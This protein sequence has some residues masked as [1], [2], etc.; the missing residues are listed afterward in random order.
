MGMWRTGSHLAGSVC[1]ALGKAK[2]HKLATCRGPECSAEISAVQ[3]SVQCNQC[4][5]EISAGLERLLEVVLAHTMS[6]FRRGS[7]Q[8]LT[9]WAQIWLISYI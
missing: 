4:S 9:L 2:G 5:A 8:L 7:G 6:P 1:D 3:R